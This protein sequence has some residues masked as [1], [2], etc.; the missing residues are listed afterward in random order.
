MAKNRNLP[1]HQRQIDEFFSDNAY[2]VMPLVH[3]TDGF[4]VPWDKTRIVA[5]LNKET[6]LAETMF[7]IPAISELTADRLAD[8]V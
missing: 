3:T 2:M 7:D 6:Q 8:E 1:Q 5:M 4:L